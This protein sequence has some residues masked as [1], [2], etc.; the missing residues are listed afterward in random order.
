MRH[1]FAA[2]VATVATVVVLS[3]AA[4]AATKPE[5]VFGGKVIVS[6]KSFP[7]ESKSPQAYIASVKKQS[8]DRFVEDK[9]KGQWK[10]YY[11]AFFKKYYSLLRV[12]TV[13]DVEPE[14]ARQRPFFESLTAVFPDVHLKLETRPE[15]LSTRIIDFASGLLQITVLG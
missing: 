3:P 15:N 11:A 6:E 8:R 13:N 5:D 2:L 12:E 1:A 9:E 14:V 10:I 7:L 4:R